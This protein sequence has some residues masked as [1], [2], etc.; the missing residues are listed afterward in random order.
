MFT[1]STLSFALIFAMIQI[2]LFH[3]SSAPV[4]VMKKVGFASYRTVP[5]FVPDKLEL[6]SKISNE[7]ICLFFPTIAVV[8]RCSLKE[9]FIKTSQNSQ[10]T[11]RARVYFLVKL[12]ASS[13]RPATLS[14]GRLG[15]RCFSLNFAKYL[16]TPFFIE[17]LG[18]LFFFCKCPYCFRNIAQTKSLA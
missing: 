11:T 17:H 9:V 10:K 1:Y 6:K 3:W 16:R 8:R 13:L 18:C 7:P 12:Q 4:H 15:N 2:K 5:N 14:K